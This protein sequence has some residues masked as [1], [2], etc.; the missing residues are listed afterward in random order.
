MLN[1]ESALS[2]ASALVADIFPATILAALG[3]RLTVARRRVAVALGCV[4]L[5]L[6]LADLLM[7]S[8]IELADFQAYEYGQGL[9][10]LSVILAWLAATAAFV[11]G[12]QGWMR[13]VSSVSMCAVG[14]YWFVN[15]WDCAQVTVIDGFQRCGLPFD[16]RQHG[17]FAGGAGILWPGLFGN[18][19]IALVGA[20][21]LDR[22]VTLLSSWRGARAAEGRRSHRL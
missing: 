11:A 4:F 6:A 20:V 2:M 17:G 15:S 22:L 12:R 3:S 13:R 7:F 9:A 1:W 14:L 21:S 5:V 19:C 16:A 8:H 10:I 18:L